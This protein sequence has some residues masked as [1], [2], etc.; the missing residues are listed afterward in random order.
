MSKH[1]SRHCPVQPALL[2][3]AARMLRLVAP[4][5]QVRTKSLLH[6]REL[7]YQSASVYRE[8]NAREDLTMLFF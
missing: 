5:E 7:Q 4:G 8:I 3:W 2:E 6:L 1:G